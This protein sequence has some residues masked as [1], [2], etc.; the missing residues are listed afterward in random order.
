[1]E[2]VDGSSEKTEMNVISLV[3]KK[4]GGRDD[5]QF[6]SNTLIDDTKKQG[7]RKT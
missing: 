4:F 2:V 5:F 1:M 7:K 6:L 3:Y